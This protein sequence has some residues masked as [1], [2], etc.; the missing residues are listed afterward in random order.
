MLNPFLFL[1][2]YAE[3]VSFLSLLHSPNVTTQLSLAPVCLPLNI[4]NLLSK[5]ILVAALL[6]VQGAHG[7]WFFQ[8]IPSS[9]Y[10][11]SLWALVEISSLPPKTQILWSYTNA[12]WSQRFFH[13]ASFQFLILMTEWIN[14][15][16]N[17]RE[18]LIQVRYPGDLSAIHFHFEA[19]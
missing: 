2:K 5:T 16:G 18:Y 4:H 13:A 11:T 9:E 15:P 1:L 14:L 7:V 17:I 6:F 3:F 19:L 12:P 10:Q 8:F